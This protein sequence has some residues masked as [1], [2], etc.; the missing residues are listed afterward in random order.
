MK[1]LTTTSYAI[2]GLLALR[3]WSGYE[4]S[5]QMRRNV[6]EFW[7]RAE[8]GLYDEPKNLVAHGF[9]STSHESRGRRARTVYTI[10][11]AGRRALGA[12]LAERGSTRPQFESEAVLRI[13][14]A[15]H[16]RAEDA[17]ATLAELQD[18][19]RELSR[20][21]AEISRTYVEGRGLY[22][23][24]VHTISLVN[25]FFADYFAVI[26]SWAAWAR[27]QIVAWGDIS[28]PPADSGPLDTLAEITAL[29]PVRR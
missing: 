28:R 27:E 29:R 16:G 11:P 8:R 25:R 13:A 10:T 9:A 1:K 22:P 7:P 17:L 24:R 3:P 14:F 26:D 4:L 2:L 19:V 23:E 21:A 15:E 5:Q 18:Q 20:F 12:W 6:G